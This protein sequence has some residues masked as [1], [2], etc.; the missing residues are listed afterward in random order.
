MS[1]GNTE[2]PKFYFGCE[3]LLN[4][5]KYLQFNISIMIALNNTSSDKWNLF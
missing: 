5:D 4:F 1:N 3:I 2:K